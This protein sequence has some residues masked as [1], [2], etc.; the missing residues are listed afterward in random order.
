MRLGKLIRVALGAIG[1]LRLSR[2]SGK[3]A[4]T[5]SFGAETRL[6]FQEGASFPF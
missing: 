3:S 5:G 4:A 2:V 6:Y 1:G